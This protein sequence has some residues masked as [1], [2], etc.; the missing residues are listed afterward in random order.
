MEIGYEFTFRDLPTDDV[1]PPTEEPT[2][3][4]P[5]Y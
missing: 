1:P 2:T 3:D 4:E 5:P